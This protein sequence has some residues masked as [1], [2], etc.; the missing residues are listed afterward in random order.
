V[1]LSRLVAGAQFA[2]GAVLPVRGVPHV[3]LH[4]PDLR[5]RARLEHTDQGHVLL[6][7]GEAAHLTRRVSDFLKAEARRDF[8]TAAAHYAARLGVTLGRISIKDTRS[9]W[10]SCSARGDLSFSWRLILA[11]P[12]VLDYLAAHEV[13]HLREMNHSANY[14]AILEELCP[15]TARAETWLK[16]HG[17]SLHRYGR[18]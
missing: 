2:H 7:P 9:R 4:R 17:A 6:V 8:E 15:A 10:G 1:R 3:V 12:E 5:G 14:W 16:A 18:G 11:P 13:A